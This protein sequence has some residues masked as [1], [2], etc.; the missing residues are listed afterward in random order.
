[1]QIKLDVVPSCRCLDLTFSKLEGGGSF[2]D[3][4]ATCYIDILT[5]IYLAPFSVRMK[6]N[7]KFHEIL[8]ITFCVRATKNLCYRYFP[9]HSIT[10]ICFGTHAYLF[11]P[12]KGLCYI[13]STQNNCCEFLVYYGVFVQSVIQSLT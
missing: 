6:L 12:D 2:Q 1:M 5:K 13:F 10:K 3:N 11:L 7:I 9:K 4:S 8:S